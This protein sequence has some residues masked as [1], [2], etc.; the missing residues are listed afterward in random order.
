MPTITVA[1]VDRLVTNRSAATRSYMAARVA[2]LFRDGMLSPK[3]RAIA[4]DVLRAFVEDAAVRVREAVSLNLKR[5]PFL[6]HDLAVT[7]AEDVDSVAVPF[8]EFSEVLTDEDLI[9]IVA[10]YGTT[11]HCAVA[12]R[13]TVSAAVS[14]ALIATRNEGVVVTLVRN[15]GAR[16]LEPSLH[17]IVDAF[18]DSEAVNEAMVHRDEL[19]LT[20]A[21]RLIAVVSDSLRRYLVARHDMPR[22]LAD[23]VTGLG[24]ERAIAELV[25]ADA[26]PDE[27]ERLVRDLHRLNRLTPSLLLRMLCNGRIAFF[28]AGLATR[29]AMPIEHT[30]KLLWESWPH[31]FD[32]LYRR[33]GLP[34]KFHSALRAAAEVILA[35]GGPGPDDAGNARRLQRLL[36]ALAD[37]DD[38]G[39]TEDLESVLSRLQRRAVSTHQNVSC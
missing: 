29:A 25:P 24:R 14:D 10:E 16:I 28:E 27:L 33:T 18:A 20:V 8:L 2:S 37:K 38:G 4:E 3:E 7:L 13:P 9:R 5:C 21:S 1:D 31:G 19:P 35:P 30:R 34:R 36:Q 26:G 6:P 22:D 32:A 39:G 11:K 15:D 23:D 12:R 17:K